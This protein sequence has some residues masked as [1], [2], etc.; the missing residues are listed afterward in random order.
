MDE[1]IGN[2]QLAMRK[3]GYPETPKSKNWQ[4]T[5]RN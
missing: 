4:H 3:E 2:K 1:S 5:I